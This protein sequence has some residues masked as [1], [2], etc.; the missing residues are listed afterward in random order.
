MVGTLLALVLLA[1]GPEATPSP[2]PTPFP[3]QPT[4]GDEEIDEIEREPLDEPEILPLPRVKRDIPEMAIVPSLGLGGFS[5]KD[6][7]DRSVVGAHFWGG[8]LIHP[9][10]STLGP[11]MGMG[12]SFDLVSQREGVDAETWYGTLEMRY[13][14]AWLVSPRKYEGALFPALAVYAIGGWRPERETSGRYR[15][16]M[17]LSSPMLMALGAAES[18]VPIPSMVEV[19]V[20]APN[21]KFSGD[22]TRLGVRAGWQF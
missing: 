13:G 8:V 6:G 4:P 18:C 1:A 20:D 10:P 14:I 11:F 9:A 21:A 2:S 12:A 16:G 3:S 5:G 15:A 22:D 19:V 7:R 17:G